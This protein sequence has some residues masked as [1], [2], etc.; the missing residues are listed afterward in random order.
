MSFRRVVVTGIGL[1][2]PLGVGVKSSWD[3]I[4]EGRSGVKPITRFDISNLACKIASTVDEG[5]FDPEKFIDPR[6]VHKMDLFIQY[7]IAAATEAIEDSG[8]KISNELE[9]DRTGLILGSGIGGL[10]T[11]EETSVRFHRENNGKVSPFFI[12]AS[13]INL[14]AGHVSIK[15][16][17]TGPNHAIVTACSTGAHA[18][19]EA[20]RMIQYGNVDVMIA[21]GAE[22]P[23]TPAGIAGFVAARTLSTKYNSAPETASR[24][25][26]QGRDGFVMGEGAGVLVL[27]EYEHAVAR[28]A[29]IYAELAGY[30]STGDAHHITS[31]HPSGRGAYR[32]MSDALKD[33][34]ILKPKSKLKSCVF[35]T[36]KHYKIAPFREPLRFCIVSPFL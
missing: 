7:G 10:G 13:L 29:K 21:G 19:G 34:K 11:I 17:F 24:P 9:G 26:D 27:E 30:G 1:V 20:M 5:K 15:Y 35:K 2:T 36:L 25:W 6:N 28:G 4:V 22:A 14:F 33:A 32:A 12:P 31:P 8:W 16:G 23:I 18:V 3:G